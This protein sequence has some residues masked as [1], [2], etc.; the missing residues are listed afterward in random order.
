M[1]KTGDPGLDNRRYDLDWLRNFGILLLVP[2]HSARVFDHWEP[3]YVKNDDLSWGLSW[4]I[5]LTSYWFMPLLF[6]LAGAASWYALQKKSNLQYIKERFHRLLVPFLFGVLFIV[7]PQGYFAMSNH[8]GEAVNLFSFISFFFSD[9]SDLS[10]YF[11]TFTPAH[12]WFILYLFV[13]S[14]VAIPIFAVFLDDSRKS[15]I[16]TFHRVFSKATVFIPSSLVLALTQLFPAPGGQN[17]FF[18]LV[19]FVM[20]FIVSSNARYLDMFQWIRGKAL[21]AILFLVPAWMVLSFHYKEAALFSTVITILRAISIWLTLIVIISFGNKFLNFNHRIIAYLN[22]AAFPIYI[23]H[24]SILVSSAYF[25]VKLN[26]SVL[27]KY[28]ML[29]SVTLVCSLLIYEGLIKRT[30]LTCR[31]FGVKRTRTLL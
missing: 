25:I 31:L 21:L 10:G 8:N 12:L 1:K 30:K 22:E 16:E 6:W 7:P 4:F 14:L 26:I 3:F 15:I 24:Q 29:M 9:W 5:S 17:P 23:V 11:G 18:F 28:I 19:L 27:L 2:F 20:G 13:L